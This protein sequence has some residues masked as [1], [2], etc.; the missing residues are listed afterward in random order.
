MPNTP[1][2]KSIIFAMLAFLADLGA[3][4]LLKLIDEL[5]KAKD[6]IDGALDSMR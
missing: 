4:M 5:S 2:K 3:E 6:P 1:G